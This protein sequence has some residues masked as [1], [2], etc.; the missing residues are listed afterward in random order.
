VCL[1]EAVYSYKMLMDFYHMTQC[2][3]QKTEYLKIYFTSP[4]RYSSVI[5][6]EPPHCLPAEIQMQIKEEYAISQVL[7]G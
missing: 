3:I 5:P 1:V 7:K 2:Y 6:K 4:A